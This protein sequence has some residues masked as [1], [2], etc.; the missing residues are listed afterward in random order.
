MEAAGQMINTR[1][2]L[3]LLNTFFPLAR[4]DAASCLRMVH[5]NAHVSGYTLQAQ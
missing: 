1:P 4:L 2:R 5:T 3:K